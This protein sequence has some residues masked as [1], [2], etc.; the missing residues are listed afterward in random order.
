M[1][2]NLPAPHVAD[3]LPIDGVRIG[4]TQAGIK[5][6]DRKDLTVVLIDEG[7]AE[8]FGP[9]PGAIT[10][11]AG[12]GKLPSNKDCP[13]MAIAI[14]SAIVKLNVPACVGVPTSP[15]TDNFNPG[16]ALPPATE[17]SRMKE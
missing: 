4:V 7:A 2:V 10:M 12:K 17:K 14:R 3:L 13:L 5:K 9:L 6:A 11:L 16:G 15:S 1:P 8:R